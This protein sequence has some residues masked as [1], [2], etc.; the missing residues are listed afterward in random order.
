MLLPIHTQRVL[1]SISI[2]V[3]ALSEA[4]DLAGYIAS[5]L[6]LTATSTTLRP[7]RTLSGSSTSWPALWTNET[8]LDLSANAGSLAS[9]H[10]GTTSHSMTGIVRT[11]TYT[12]STLDCWAQWTQYWTATF[13]TTD[14]AATK[15]TT[16][17]NT[18]TSFPIA[19]ETTDGPWTENY[20]TATVTD[21]QYE[22]P[23]DGNFPYK[24]STYTTTLLETGYGQIKIPTS[25]SSPFTVTGTD[26]ET[27]WAPDSLLGP[28]TPRCT[29]PP[30]VPQC[31]SDYDEW[32]V[33]GA[34]ASIKPSC[35]QASLDAAQ[36]STVISARYTGYPIF[37]NSALDAWATNGTSTWWPTSSSYAPSCTLGCQ[38][39]AITGNTV[40][41]YYWPATT[42]SLVE[43]GTMTARPSALGSSSNQSVAVVA[44]VGNHTLTSPTVYISYATL[45]A[46]NSCSG[47]GRT[48]WNTVIPLSNNADLSSLA[49]HVLDDNIGY[50][51][52]NWV[53]GS[54]DYVTKPFNYHDLVEPIPESIYNQMPACQVQSHAYVTAGISG[55]FTCSPHVAYAPLIAIP[56]QVFELDPAWASCTAWYGGLYDPPKALQGAAAEATPTVPSVAEST[57]ASA[58]STA[59]AELPSETA[60][61]HSSITSAPSNMQSSGENSSGSVVST[62][63]SSSADTAAASSAGALTEQI[64]SGQVNPTG[65]AAQAP[66]TSS[67]GVFEPSRSPGLTQDTTTQT[68]SAVA[69]AAS[70]ILEPLST[71]NEGD[72]DPAVTSQATF[73]A[74]SVLAA[75]ERTRSSNL[76]DIVTPA[77]GG[78]SESG[79]VIASSLPAVETILTVALPGSPTQ[80]SGTA[81]ASADGDPSFVTVSEGQTATISGLGV[82]IAQSSDI[83]LD[84]STLAY[85]TSGSAVMG[86]G[87]E[88]ETVHAAETQAQDPD[89]QQGLVTTVG[90][91]TFT[92]SPVS[93]GLVLGYGATTATLSAGGAQI[94]V[95]TQI[96]SAGLSG[97]L[98]AGSST[99]ALQA[100]Q[101]SGV[102]LTLGGSAIIASGSPGQSG[103]LV[104]DGS[105]L[106]VSG[107]T[108]TINGQEVSK[109]ADGLAIGSSTT[110]TLSHLTSTASDDVLT[111]ES[112][113]LSRSTSNSS[114]TSSQA[115]DPYT[116]ET[117]L[118][119]TTSGV[120]RVLSSRELWWMGMAVLAAQ[121]RERQRG[122]ERLTGGE[123]GK[124][125][126]PPRTPIHLRSMA[127]PPKP[128][129]RA[130]AG[131]TSAV[132]TSTTTATAATPTSATPALPSR[133]DSLNA[134]ASRTASN[135]SSPMNRASPYSSP[136]G[137]GGGSSY[138]SPYNRFGGGMSGGMGGMYGSSYGGYGGGM[139]GGMGYGMGGGY[140]QQGMY[141]APQQ[142]QSLSQTMNQSTQATFQMIESIVG[143]FGGFAQMLEST[144]MATHSSFF[145]M[146]SVAEQFGNLR[147][148]LG[149]M[150]GIFTIMRWF[151]TAV[152]KITG[153]PPPA[154]SKELTPANF[155]AFSG[156]G[157]GPDGAGAQ[158]K[159]S[160]KPFIFFIIAVFGLPYLMGKLIR[161]LAASQEAEQQKQLANAPFGPDGQQQ[162]LDPSKL[163]F[164]RVLYDYTPQM[165]PGQQ[166]TEGVDL[167]IKKGD[168]VAVLSKTDPMGQ[169]SEWW[170]CRARDGR[171]GY[172]P[173]PY[174]ETIQR[175]PQGQI[176]AKSNATSPA[177]SRVNTM[178]GSANSGSRANSM[179][180]TNKE[181]ADIQKAE[182]LP[183]KIEGKPGDVTVESFQKAALSS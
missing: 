6:G 109:G 160:R 108:Q 105:T 137:Y 167:S 172:L 34:R 68:I 143:A 183:P 155:A 98:F 45:Y 110:M 63:S 158:P 49:Y 78:P 47:V 20:G 62:S 122:L 60:G 103:A 56:T 124:Q 24:T 119:S 146:V 97:Q 16:L 66:S 135:Y 165:Q 104:I 67:A 112:S 76:P 5:G 177:H 145:A 57:S 102:V 162:P 17:L 154:S 53:G 153:R 129:E 116:P 19:Y 38:K 181:K 134:V 42:A 8:D 14:G 130:G 32:V 106:S 107:P 117:P 7:A 69:P 83:L 74:L 22:D 142:D 91:Q 2:A 123:L 87:G 161:A 179:A 138:S 46:S 128:W 50:E 173:S 111:L 118:P 71:S 93:D 88:V 120:E 30:L 81:G 114:P 141:G 41:V 168:L 75:A 51:P 90:S 33:G 152:A 85:P 100:A 149:S 72:T 58:G 150:L 132:P 148:T 79:V 178:T 156:G 35:S 171:M 31:Q 37:G 28:T 3:P 92:A 9:L 164:C 99:L 26:V 151:R 25:T 180:I 133:P 121:E 44:V 43:N 147:Q 40:Q 80:R 61:G 36:C 140:G 55:N 89:E 136:Y 1:L 15:T 54:W 125:A 157:I 94:T 39:C 170:R 139:G 175:K 4:S 166:Y 48:V 96:L 86:T 174:L 101:Q 29:L 131:A 27:W 12:N 126:P 77:D 59:N 95:G 11:A 65:T 18:Y 82:V 159:P 169:P 52:G 182:K 13:K 21:I 10:A 64:V 84:G 113:T 144:Y 23:Q 127:S 163:D 73:N 176:A 115:D 70:S